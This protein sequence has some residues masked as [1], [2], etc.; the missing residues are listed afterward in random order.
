MLLDRLTRK[1]GLTLTKDDATWLNVAYVAFA[2]L[3]GFF[4]YQALE[5]VGLQTGLVE[6]FEWFSAVATIVSVCFGIGASIFLKSSKERH[7][8]FLAAI[9]E[10]RKVSWPTWVDTKRMTLIVVVVVGIFG[11]IVGV[12]DFFWASALKHLLA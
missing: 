1:E 8:Y 5:L 7:E 9:A 2:V 3:S 12:F 6:R 11:V 10:L 4:F